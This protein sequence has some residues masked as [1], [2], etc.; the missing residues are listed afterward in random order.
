MTATPALGGDA[1][2]M[3]RLSVML[4][5]QYFVFGAWYATTGN[6]MSAHGMT[7]AIYWAYTVGPLAGLL[8]PF[9]I[10]IV[11]DRYFATERV[12][13]VLLVVGALP[14][15]LSA[16]VPAGR[17]GPFIAL[18]MLHT[19]C[20]FPTLGLASTLAFHHI[21]DRERQFPLVRLF[22]T[23][24]WIVAGGLVSGLLLADDTALPLQIGAGGCLVFG[25]YCF[26]LPHTP[27]PAKGRPLSLRTILGLD[28]IRQ[29]RSVPFFVFLACD[30]IVAI[31]YAMYYAYVPVF[32]KAAGVTAPAFTLT[33]GQWTELLVMALLPLALIRLGIKWMIVLGMGAWAIRYAFFAF[34]TTGPTV[35]FIIAGILLH[36]ISFSF[37]YIAAQIYLDRR[38][39]P[40]I[41]GQAQ[42]LL[43][44]V[45][46]GMGMLM[47]AQLGGWFFNRVIGEDLTN[48]AHWQT[49]WLIPVGIATI[50]TA[51]VILFFY[52]DSLDSTSSP[53]PTP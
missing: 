8:A 19:L 25:L 20:F 18:L 17:P 46:S 48:M 9:F 38:A 42:G 12:M 31:P 45:R 29:L 53:N 14:L 16:L 52:D 23:L 49:L 10:G 43:V 34:A 5:L 3:V 6:Y 33:F 2:L 41:R 22:G 11:A 30:V 4:F 37:V 27:P 36:G 26:S 47:G 32:M 44:M 1:S 40:D 35:P 13:G 24:G 50:M 7:S 39:T 15:G 21:S 28:A 51:V